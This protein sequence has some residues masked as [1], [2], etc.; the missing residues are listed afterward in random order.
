MIVQKGKSTC[1]NRTRP[2]Q[3]EGALMWRGAVVD[4]RRQAGGGRLG[5]E[6]GLRWT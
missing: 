5:D 6:E 1:E 2:A 4:C 3:G